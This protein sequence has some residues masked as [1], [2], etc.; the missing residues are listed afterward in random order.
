[1]KRD[2]WE[3]V[4]PVDRISPDPKRWLGL[5]PEWWV[6][7]ALGTGSMMGT[8]NST[9]VSTILPVIRDSFGADLSSIEWVLMAYLLTVSVFLLTFGRLGDIWGHKRVYN[10]GL[11]VFVLSSGLCSLSPTEAFL[12][13]FRCLQAI[14]GA[15]LIA[16]SQAIL[17]RSFP[18]EQRGQLLGLLYTIAS[19]GLLVGPSLGGYL[20]YAFGWRSVFYVNVFIGAV[21]IGMSLR[22]LPNPGPSEHREPF[23]ILGAVTM[24]VGLGALLLAISKGQELGWTS[25]FTLSSIA[26]SV[27]FLALFVRTE[28]TVTHPMLD[29]SLFRSRGFSFAISSTFITYVCI[30]SGLFLAPFYLMQ[31]RHFS[32]SLSGQLYSIQP[33]GMLVTAPLGGYLSDRIN[34]RLLSTLGAVCIAAGL[35]ALHGL[36]AESGTGAI[37]FSMAVLGLGN[38]LFVGPNANII[39]GG[40]PPERQ[41]VA[42]GIVATARN[43]GMVFGVAVTGAI[44]AGQMAQRT[45]SQAGDQASFIGAFQDTLFI[46]TFVGL[47]GAAAAMVRQPA[48]AGAIAH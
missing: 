23:D 31:G 22:L 36:D 19:L 37:L 11:A 3:P 24:G 43:L 21:A 16:N 7:I 26:V 48:R 27:I 15:M 12:I 29:M 28:A 45:A 1:M 32:P 41:G 47:I 30:F 44:L 13:G 5:R 40:A 9:I 42:S 33:L 17:T 25:I 14:G 10:A 38:G 18:P 39:M 34:P 46:M 35:F 20:S 2:A 4:A 8:M 6:L